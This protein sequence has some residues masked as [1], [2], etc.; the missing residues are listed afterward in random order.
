MSEDWRRIPVRLREGALLGVSFRPRQVEAFGLDGP[1]TLSALL[2]HP[3]EII[4]L[5]AY[6]DRIETTPGEFDTSE[7]DWQFDAAERAGKQVMVSV[8]AIKNFG[9]PEFYVPRHQLPKP[10]RE[11]S[12]IRPENHADLHS[13][14]KRFISWV[15][16]RYRGRGSLV[17]WQLE[18]EGV[19]PLGFEHSWR[20]GRDFVEGELAVLRESDPSRPVMMNGFLPMASLVRLSQWWRTRDQG[21]S[22]AVAT[23]LADIRYRLLPPPCTLEIRSQDPLRR[24]VGRPTAERPIRRP[25]CASQAMDGRGGPGGTPGRCRPCR[26]ARIGRR[27]SPAVRIT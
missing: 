1:A 15:V 5:A 19:D 20:L 4:R 7:L 26:P 8:G 18:H 13:A 17:A 21:D 11:G 10:L 22:L 25:A 9:Y 12:V 6:W 24:R 14:A 16:M 23:E 27:C 2:A 3:F